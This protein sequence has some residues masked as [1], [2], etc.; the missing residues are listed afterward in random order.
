MGECLPGKYVKRL[1]T[2][3]KIMLG[4]GEDSVNFTWQKDGSEFKGPGTALIMLGGF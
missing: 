4:L 3:D 1:T 2:L